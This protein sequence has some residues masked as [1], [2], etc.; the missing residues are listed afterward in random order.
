MIESHE[1][2]RRPR[3]LQ[4]Q[5]GYDLMRRIVD[6]I[7]NM[8]SKL[9]Q[10]DTVMLSPQTLDLLQKA[11]LEMAPENTPMPLDIAGVKVAVGETKGYA[12]AFL[13]DYIPWEKR[14]ALVDG[15]ILYG[16]V[17]KVLATGDER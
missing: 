6:N 17:K 3:T 15:N 7:Q 10:P 14:K 2:S 1:G 16:D 9:M 5:R 11:W 4:A 12:Y 13:R 8:R